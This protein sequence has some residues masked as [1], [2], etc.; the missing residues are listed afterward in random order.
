MLSATDE[1][2][3]SKRDTLRDYKRGTSMST[4]GME[5]VLS[6]AVG[7]FAGRYADDKLGTAPW[8]SVVGFLLGVAAAVR[9]VHRAWA[10]MQAIAKIEEREQGNPPPLYP[11]EPH[12]PA[13][14]RRAERA[15]RSR[16]AELPKHD[17]EPA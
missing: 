6:I 12:E 13:R 4:I 1:M 9:S 2:H 5:L 7:F 11:H 8:F 14:D 17:D 10:Q 16:E 15:S 3:H